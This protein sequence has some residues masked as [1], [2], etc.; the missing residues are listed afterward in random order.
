MWKHC[1][2]I[3]SHEPRHAV[4]GRALPPRCGI[5]ANFAV[6]LGLDGAT[7]RSAAQ[8]WVVALP[9]S[10]AVARERRGPTGEV[11]SI[12]AQD[13]SVVRILL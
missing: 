1:N 2:P 10:V 4:P 9:G 8:A 3:G 6:R 13:G 12:V 11:A 7:M 5:I